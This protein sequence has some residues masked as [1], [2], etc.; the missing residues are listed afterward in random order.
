M[1]EN[2]YKANGPDM[3]GKTEVWEEMNEPD[4]M[5]DIA[6]LAGKRLAEERAERFD[7]W[8]CEEHAYSAR[9]ERRK[10]ALFRRARRTGGAKGI[11]GKRTVLR[12]A[13]VSAAALVLMT[14]AAAAVPPIRELVFGDRTRTLPDRTTE[15]YVHMTIEVNEDASYV[16][17]GSEPTY[18]PEGWTLGHVDEIY[19]PD[20]TEKEGPPDAVFYVY[21]Y[22]QSADPEDNGRT[23]GTIT[24]HRIRFNPADPQ[25]SVGYG[26]GMASME[27]N[28]VMIGD[29]E[30]TRVRT[31]W[32]RGN[33]QTGLL[34]S[35]GRYNYY[36]EA[37]TEV[38]PGSFMEGRFVAVPYEEL[39]R[40]AL[41]VSK[42]PVAAGD[43]QVLFGFIPNEWEAPVT[44]GLCPRCG[45]AEIRAVCTHDPI[46]N[47]TPVT[48][49]ATGEVLYD[50]DAP[51][52]LT[53]K[54]HDPAHGE[55]CYRAEL[56]CW[57][58]YE[59]PACGY[60]VSGTEQ[61]TEFVIHAEFGA[62][63]GALLEAHRAGEALPEGVTV[64]EVCGLPQSEH[65]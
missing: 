37:M 21:Q 54:C 41:S 48:L 6:I 14:A 8:N 43:E 49:T 58:D 11:P 31:V 22:Q 62:D 51:M 40:M 36:L 1:M 18:I 19:A 38:I 52:D 4:K 2:E 16:E 59:C 50:E 29:Y 47:E 9:F 34:W 33:V 25:M 7:G 26:E 27:T 53:V 60:C 39:V 45:K 3:T 35:D 12:I 44:E 55:D 46:R 28:S 30:G 63:Y 23:G 24:L 10:E 5:E 13:C 42:D 56:N 57:T 61:H 32:N 65:P 64:E 20:D 17:T 15:R